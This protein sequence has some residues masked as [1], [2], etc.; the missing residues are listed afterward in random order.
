MSR[1]INKIV[2]IIYYPHVTYFCIRLF[3]FQAY[4]RF[5]TLGSVLGLLVPRCTDPQVTVRHLAFDSIDL[6][7]SLATKMQ[8]IIIYF[9]FFPIKCILYKN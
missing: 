6:A 7:I 9:Y 2:G 4:S 5:N 1:I 3:Y 8:G